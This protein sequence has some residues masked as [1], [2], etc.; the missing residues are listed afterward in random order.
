MPYETIAFPNAAEA[1]TFPHN[2]AGICF[3]AKTPE[4][5]IHGIAIKR[6]AEN[7][8]Y[9]IAHECWHLFHNLLKAIDGNKGYTADVLNQEIYVYAFSSLFKD[10][11]AAYDA[12]TKAAGGKR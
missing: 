3:A 4:G 12:L 10:V 6:D 7:T 11:T 9:V 8:P 5:N 2:A 1:I